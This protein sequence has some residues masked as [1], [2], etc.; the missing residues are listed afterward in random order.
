[1]A[2]RPIQDFYAYFVDNLQADSLLHYLRD[3][4]W[5]TPDEC[6]TLSSGQ[7]ARRQKV[8]KILLL[9]PRKSTSS[10]DGEKI[11]VE[12]IIWSGQQ[13]L[14]RKLGYTDHEINE[15]SKRNPSATN[16]VPDSK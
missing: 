6:D 8:E 16:P 12:C 7:I 5:L 3:R 1:M 10:F 15:I 4:K 14:T 13:E 2:K 11:L 9:L